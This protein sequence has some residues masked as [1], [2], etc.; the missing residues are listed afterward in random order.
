VRRISLSPTLVALFGSSKRVTIVGLL[1]VAMVV[2]LLPTLPTLP[3]LGVEQFLEE[4]EPEAIDVRPLE[5][6]AAPRPEFAQSDASSEFREGELIVRFKPG[7]AA[8]DRASAFSSVDAS[9]EGDLLLP[10]AHILE[11]PP[12]LS[13]EEAI[14]QLEKN[15]NV[16]YAEP[17]YIY[18]L[19]ANPNDP[20][21]G[22]LWG[23]HNT[24]QSVNGATGTADADI[25]APEAW[26]VTIGST[27]VL[28]GIIDSGIAYD[29]PD[30]AP[31]IW[32]NPGE[33]G[34]GKDTNGVDDDSNG[35][36]DD[37]RGWD[38]VGD[39][40]DPRDFNGHGTH[41]SGTVG[42]RGDNS[43]GVTGVSQQVSMVMAQACGGDGSCSSAALIDAYMYVAN[44][45]ARI[46]NVS[47]SG[48]TFSQAA[49]DAITANPGTLYVVAAG[50]LG[51]DNDSTPRYP[52]AY[53]LANIVCVAASDSD[54]AMAGF[55]NF[56]A[57]SVDLAAPGVNIYSTYPSHV[58][59]FS[60]DFES[61]GGNWTSGGTNNTWGIV[62]CTG[63]GLHCW[64]DSPAGNYL[65][66]TNSWIQTVASIDISTGAAECHVE[67]PT[68]LATESGF[69]GV[70]VEASP[71][72]AAWT[73]LTGWSG[74]TGGTFI[75]FSTLIDSGIGSS[76]YLRY[77]F[78]S[79]SSV[80]FDGVYFLETDVRCTDTTTSTYAF[81][82]GTS[83]ASPHVAGAAALLKAH[84]PSI[85]V[86][87]MKATLMNTV[88]I[89]GSHSG[90]TVTGGR[91][92]I[93]QAL[94]ALNVAPVASDDDYDATE[95]TQL[96]VN[97]ANGVLDNDTDADADTLTVSASDTTSAEGGTVAVAAD[98][99]FTYDPPADYNGTDTFGYTASDGGLTDTAT[100]TITVANVPDA[101]DAVDD[102]YDASENT[103][104]VVNEANGVLDNDT[105]ADAD[106]L[107]VSA[108]DTTSAEGGTVAVAADGSF[109]YDP[110]ADY[111]GTDTFDYTAS[112]G[113]LTDTATVTIT[114]KAPSGG[115]GGG[116][117][118]PPP[119]PA[120][121]AIDTSSSCPASTPSAGFTDIGT[122]DATT[123]L[124]IACL[125]NYE[126]SQGT[127]PTTYTPF[128]AV[129]R[130]QMALFLTRQ[131]E[132]HGVNLPDRSDQGFTDIGTLDAA[133]QKAI[134][135]LAQLGI[136]KGTT[137]TTFSPLEN[138][139]RE[140]M[141]L[142]ISRLVTAAD[143]ALPD[144]PTDQGFTDISGLTAE[145][146]KAINQL[147]QVGIAL[148]LPSGK[149]APAG[150]TL[151]WHMALFLTRALAADGVAP[152]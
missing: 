36:I 127:S 126:I 89:I 48:P 57:T 112:D 116:G 92:N 32:I 6:D 64:T 52:C 114:V 49:S 120:P 110:P 147:T 78:T 66:N 72:A 88:D 122:L 105:D 74:S 111:N 96:V 21:F 123:Q 94:D 42:A 61:G 13:V 144:P 108:S 138:V 47:V 90:L 28:V 27:D 133:T 121:T 18:Q 71:D 51:T 134:N 98:G 33:S 4:A 125:A 15:P 140:Q 113:G 77:R 23:L 85:T 128:A 83:M 8:A 11:L 43:I 131:A 130:W 45:G 22:E 150:P 63:G 29:H 129:P 1:I 137:A 24:G 86:A 151:R 59:R 34:G 54:D 82:N 69:D 75:P 81:L 97:E 102:D 68:V 139:T 99:S 152:S 67:Y 119:P 145:S 16:S 3:A 50:N 44:L 14:G 55:S 142:F 19:D 35:L 143:V 73:V 30:L 136:S 2:M 79:D 46:A 80:Q 39:D 95:D 91:L 62:E 12:G 70:L 101:P 148:G 7:A 84:D 107:A 100:V 25:D 124:A 41:V 40:N 10:R 93:R 141:A 38:F 87:E 60:D 103:Q 65:P 53:N 118:V 5:K 135:Q 117:G 104:L 115:G 17:N 20:N 26:D 132:V 37:W 58:T 31:N 109:T 56:G 149:Y 106:T 9:V 146:Q 76:V